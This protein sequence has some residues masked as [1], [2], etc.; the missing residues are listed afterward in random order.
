MIKIKNSDPT[1]CWWRGET[2]YSKIAGGNVQRYK[3]LWK[4]SLAVSHI[5]KCVLIKWPS[6]RS[7]GHLCQADK[8]RFSQKSCTLMLI[9]ALFKIAK[10]W[11][12]FRCPSTGEWLN[13]LWYHEILLGNK[14]WTI[15]TCHNWDGS[16]GVMLSEKS[17]F[18]KVIYCIVL[19]M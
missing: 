10:H 15:D 7:L 9:A 18:R 3:P 6:N 2:D 12:Q 11:K 8:N 13:I 4:S 5:T 14:E 1:I 17:Q 19:F 16:K